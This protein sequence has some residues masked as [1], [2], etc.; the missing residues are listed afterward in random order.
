MA[1][2][3]NEKKDIKAIR[4]KIISF[5]AVFI[6]IDLIF[7]VGTTNLIIIKIKLFIPTSCL[8]LSQNCP[9]DHPFTQLIRPKPRSQLW[10]LFPTYLMHPQDLSTVSLEYT[11]FTNTSHP[12]K[13]HTL[14]RTHPSSS[15]II[16]IS[17]GRRQ[18]SL[19]P[20]LLPTLASIYHTAAR[21]ISTKV[22]S[23]HYTSLIPPMTSHYSNFPHLNKLQSSF[24]VLW[25]PSW[26][27]PCLPLGWSFPL[28]HSSPS[29]TAQSKALA[30][31]KQPKASPTQGSF[32]LLPYPTLV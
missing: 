18:G 6:I 20:F 27:P 21:V 1:K 4:Y 22:T 2:F 16:L 8:P 9:W 19:M 17:R 15:V 32:S 12:L 28:L 24:Q 31:L 10:F 13:H 25:N 26:S 5:L 23:H 29:H 7:T 3:L 11:P 14:V 30:F